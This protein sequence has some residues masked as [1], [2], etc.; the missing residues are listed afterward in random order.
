MQVAYRGGILLQ[1]GFSRII[2]DPVRKTPGSVVSHAHMDHLTSGGVMT[3]ETLEVLRARRGSGTGIELPY[4]REAELNGF[5]VTLRDAGHVF[6]SA[7]V[8]VDDLLYTGDFN[9]EGGATCGKAVPEKVHGLVIDATYGKPGLSFPDKTA[10]EAD[11]L[12]WLEMELAEGPVA[13]GGY[14]FGKSQELIALVNRLGVE[15]AVADG[16]ADL[17][18]IYVR[19]GV[20]LAYRRISSL[21]ESERRDPRVY[22]LPPGWLR[23]PLDESVS[24][25]GGLRLR[26]AYVSGWTAFFDFTRRYG[27]DAQFPL[28]DHADFDDI[29]AFVEACEPR[30]V[31]PVFSHAADLARAIDRR[32]HIKAVPLREP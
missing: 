11:L 23:P 7:M 21:A 6:G 9:P 26:S 5:Y 32:L 17:A 3:P 15:V 8:R 30:V 28:S 13:L 1:E 14:V 19:H 4:N 25:L 22:I 12:N 20:P 24:W 16:I 31:Y 29:V 10:V 2:L 18:D 27:L